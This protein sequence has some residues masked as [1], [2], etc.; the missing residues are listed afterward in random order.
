MAQVSLQFNPFQYILFPGLNETLASR[1]SDQHVKN[2]YRYV[3][4]ESPVDM[5]TL[6]QPYLKLIV[7]TVEEKIFRTYIQH[8]ILNPLRTH[9]SLQRTV[10]RSNSQSP[11]ITLIKA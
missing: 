4:T 8:D 6:V 10:T 5:S 9:E 2:I 3:C 7:N 11:Q 1:C